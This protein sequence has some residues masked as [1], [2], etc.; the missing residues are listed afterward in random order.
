MRA[1]AWTQWV[2][3][4]GAVLLL[5]AVALPGT[6]FAA[7]TPDIKKFLGGEAFAV[8]TGTTFYAWTGADESVD[9][10]FVRADVD[11]DVDADGIVSVIDPQ[12]QDHG[13]CT[14]KHD[15]K[16]EPCEFAKLSS[17]E[18]GVWR[19]EYRSEGDGRG[20][21]ANWDIAVTA[22]GKS[23]SGRVWTDRY[24]VY[25]DPG[26]GARIDL[27][28]LS[29]LGFQYRAVYRGYNG[30]WSQFEAGVAGITRAD[31]CEP[32]NHSTGGMK[33][34]FNTD[35]AACGL[36]KVFF[37]EPSADLPE[38][39]PVAGGDSTWLLSP[40]READLGAVEYQPAEPH[41]VNGQF[42]VTVTDHQGTITV[43]LDL[44][45]DGDFGDD[46]DRTIT[47]G[48]SV[49]GTS[50]VAVPWDGL[51][52]NEKPVRNNRDFN[53][54]AAI[55]RVGT[56]YFVNS[57]VEGRSGGIEVEY[58]NGPA[59][60]DRMV[61]WDDAPDPDKEDSADQSGKIDSLGGARSWDFGTN[62]WGSDRRIQEWAF[63]A[64]DIKTDTVT[65][66]T[67]TRPPKESDAAAG[68]V[69][70]WQG[71]FGWVAGAGAVTSVVGLGF[72]LF[73]SRRS[74][75]RDVGEESQLLGLP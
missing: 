57:D 55:D 43:D 36:Y 9:V 33:G 13:E 10:G 2:R 41:S 52:G 47:W 22:G 11:A 23:V 6:A 40:V 15:G 51:A 53:V 46:V 18:P 38:S 16:A 12:G 21:P 7:V 74:S 19:I 44:N 24:L 4:A 54:R 49:V 27:Y 66:V 3:V 60:G 71:P 64:V 65:F 14:I 20:V 68:P 72:L 61:Y 30:V 62:S 39:A 56:I 59:A 5:G 75:R 26:P 1:I 50:Q 29:E 58:L 48:V 70:W 37:D 34:D 28:Y 35:L 31:T 63:A 17:S 32:I 69:A 8:Q 67:P 45:G 25:Q 42:L 73:F